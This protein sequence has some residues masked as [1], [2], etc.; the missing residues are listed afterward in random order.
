MYS[1]FIFYFYYFLNYYYFSLHMYPLPDYFLSFHHLIMGHLQ[2]SAQEIWPM[3]FAEHN[4]IN[5]ETLVHKR[6]NVRLP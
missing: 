2:F 3:D 4:V 6:D 5:P 1:L